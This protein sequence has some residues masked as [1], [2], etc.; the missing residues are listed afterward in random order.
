[1]SEFASAQSSENADPYEGNI[2][3]HACGPIL[4]YAEMT[5]R[6]THLPALPGNASVLSREL[7]AHHLA[8]VRSLHIPT[9]SGIGLAQAID[10]MLRQ[11]Y[12]HR[13]PTKARTWQAI[14]DDKPYESHTDA[15]LAATV[16][17]IS[18]TGKS[19]A[20]KRAL[21]L[22]PQV[23]SHDRFPGI[24]GS[25]RQLI[26]LKIDVPGSGKIV[27]LIESLLRETDRI[28]GTEYTD[29]VMSG[30]FRRGA[31]LAH[32]WLRKIR[33]HFLGILVLDEIQNLFKIESLS[34]RRTQ[35]RKGNQ[36]PPLRIV[37]DEALKFLLTLI[38][39]STFPLIVTGT[40]DGIEALRT[41]MSTAQR[42]VTAGEHNFTHAPT[43]ED[44][45]YRKYLFPQLAEYQWFG[46]KL[47]P[48][49][50]FRTL[51]HELSAGV[52]RIYIS[53]WIHAHMRALWQG[54]VCLDE[55]HFKYAAENALGSLRPAVEALLSNDPRRLMQYE[56]SLPARV[57][58]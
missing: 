34:V 32:E 15:E 42:L 39:T 58:L 1:M 21:H 28:L 46:N 47:P 51:V 12:A 54:A 20:L 11:G 49:D 16:S 27:D 19:T 40:P 5:K 8:S 35:A 17:G 53:L 30:R 23:Y 14:Y 43:A 44:D 45:Y 36:R 31:S 26:W 38:N 24:A 33:C 9:A 50:G 57:L 56:D 52:P 3:A 10:L 18:G 41:R 7:R 2:L 55:S 48:T 13:C 25:L 22:K 6:L 29:E 4:S 37:D